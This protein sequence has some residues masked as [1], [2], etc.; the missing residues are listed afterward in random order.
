M[1]IRPFLLLG[2]TASIVPALSGDVTVRS[3]NE[4][5]F[6]IVL[7]QPI[8]ERTKNGTEVTLPD[9]TVSYR[10]GSLEYLKSGKFACL[11]D[12]AKQT[13]TLIDEEHK[14]FATIA[15]KDYADR[16]AVTMP[17]LPPD[18]KSAQESAKITVSSKKTGR[19]DVMHGVQVEESEI[20][21]LLDLPIPLPPGQTASGPLIKATMQVWLAK[22]SEAARL[23]A[24]RELAAQSWPNAK[25]SQWADPA[26]ILMQTFGAMPGLADGMSR[27]FQEIEK[28][29]PVV[30]KSHLEISMPGMIPFLE[31]TLAEGNALPKGFDPHA[32]F[33]VIDSEVDEIST[34]PIGDSLFQ[35]PTDYHPAP[36]DDVVKA[37]A[38]NF[39]KS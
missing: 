6:G 16:L 38:P 10:K 19:T 21:A 12:F 17:A 24:I 28:S 29:K 14:Q 34:A 25:F 8:A 35:V 27:M 39:P 5:R 7:P 33:S 13:I 11:M 18:S 1:Q 26:N 36:F 23:P 31:K 2:L 20:T 37:L 9:S 32:P 3:R 4:M 30:L 15:M 22:S